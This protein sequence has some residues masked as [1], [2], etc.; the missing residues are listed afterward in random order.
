MPETAVL[1]PR[2]PFNSRGSLVDVDHNIVQAS[3]QANSS[4]ES[5]QQN[6][7]KAAAQHSAA[8]SSLQIDSKASE[9]DAIERAA[10]DLNATHLISSPYPDFANQ[11]RLEDLE[12]PF[13]LFAF[14][15]SILRP[16]REDYAT[17]PYLDSFNWSEVFALLRSLCERTGFH[18]KELGFYVVIFRSKLLEGADRERLGL[19]DQKSHEEACQ[20]GGLLKYWFGSTNGERR[21]LATCKSIPFPSVEYDLTYLGR[22]LAESR[23][24]CSWRRRSMA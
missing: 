23:R 14:A 20:S 1:S 8:P 7:N 10:I 22:Y 11:L 17:A 6:D 19:L 24:C 2:S 16:I 13:R 12:A 9:Q 21:N 4:I 3:K 15:L 5:E 18:W